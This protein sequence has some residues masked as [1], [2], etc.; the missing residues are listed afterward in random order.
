MT[1]TIAIII[2]LFLVK[3][4]RI[5]Q[6]RVFLIT[7]MSKKCVFNVLYILNFK[8]TGYPYKSSRKTIGITFLLSTHVPKHQKTKRYKK[9]SIL[10][11]FTVSSLKH[12]FFS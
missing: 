2:R 12:V 3:F 11:C 6:K 9:K 1:E 4:K 5:C 8:N 10:S 7:M